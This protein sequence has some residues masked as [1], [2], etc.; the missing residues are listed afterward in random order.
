MSTRPI[1]SA[2]ALAVSLVVL[3]PACSLHRTDQS[4][5]D[6]FG[7]QL[8]TYETIRDSGLSTGW[9]VLR[10][11][12]NHLSFSEHERGP[13]RVTRRGRQSIYLV[14]KP[15]LILDGVK[16]SDYRV[17][18]NLPARDIESMRILSSMEGGV[19]YGLQAASGVIIVHT[20]F[21]DPI[22]QDTTRISQT[23]A[24]TVASNATSQQ[25]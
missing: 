16:I 10:R 20:R 15:L 1:P 25:R 5:G 24:A 7:G 23:Q 3:L 12:A 8:I 21:P 13:V 14:E 19:R 2:R 22:E 6:Q 17:L 9:E 4:A 18:V 11:Y